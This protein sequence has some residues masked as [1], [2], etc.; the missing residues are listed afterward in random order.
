MIDLKGHQNDPTYMFPMFFC[1][2]SVFNMHECWKMSSNKMHSSVGN[3]QDTSTS[4]TQKSLV[5]SM[6]DQK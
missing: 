2:S 6:E 5:L 4:A 1:L 3:K